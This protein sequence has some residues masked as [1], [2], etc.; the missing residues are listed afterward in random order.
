MKLTCSLPTAASA[1]CFQVF[2]DLLL[3]Q[4]LLHSRQQVLAFRQC[5]ADVLQAMLIALPTCDLLHLLAKFGF[6][7][8]LNGSLH[9]PIV[10]QKSQSRSPQA[11]CRSR[12]LITRR[13]IRSGCVAR[14]AFTRS[15][16]CSRLPRSP[17]TERSPLE[18]STRSMVWAMSPS[19]RR[20]RASH[21]SRH[22][23]S[24]SSI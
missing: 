2:G 23:V 8:D 5:Q 22:R 12:S 14:C 24:P 17:M 3:H 19:S 15:I 13:S 11:Y 7:C 6:K 20:G 21:H 1:R 9:S 10:S 4:Y 18:S 16:A